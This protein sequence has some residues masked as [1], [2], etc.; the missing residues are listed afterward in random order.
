MRAD[1]SHLSTIKI[2]EHPF[3]NTEELMMSLIQQELQV[4]KMFQKLVELHKQTHLVKIITSRASQ[5][6][7]MH[8]LPLSLYTIKKF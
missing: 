6:C 4:E 5:E 3:K 7:K 2:K 1:Q 8:I